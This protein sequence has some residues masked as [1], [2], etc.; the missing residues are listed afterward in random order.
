MF[1]H[2]ISNKQ[3]VAEGSDNNN[4]PHP[5]FVTGLT[6]AVIK[7][8]KKVDNLFI[9]FIFFFFFYQYFYARF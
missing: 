4:L 3:H 8:E 6:D 1:I 7:K 2:I 5:W 9:I